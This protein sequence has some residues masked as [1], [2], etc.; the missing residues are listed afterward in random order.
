MKASAVELLEVMIEEANENSK[1]LARI[2]STKIPVFYC[3]YSI[4]TQIINHIL[5]ILEL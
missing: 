2:F 5:H 4:N 3:H 1:T